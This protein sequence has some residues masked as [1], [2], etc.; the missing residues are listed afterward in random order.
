MRLSSSQHPDLPLLPMNKSGIQ[1]YHETLQWQNS[2]PTLNWTCSTALGRAI[3]PF[4]CV[5][6]FSSKSALLRNLWSLYWA[7]FK[8]PRYACS[9]TLVR[10]VLPYVFWISDLKSLT[11][12]GWLHWKNGAHFY[13]WDSVSCLWGTPQSLGT[14]LYDPLIFLQWWNGAR[15]GFRV[16][17][18]PQRHWL[19]D[20]PDL[21]Q[22]SS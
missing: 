20:G 3:H 8:G 5:Q 17:T 6:C 16:W 13:D 18:I 12:K 1:W 7:C 4:V 9:E 11:R 15:M 19:L 2:C 21:C 14:P 22:V 10:P